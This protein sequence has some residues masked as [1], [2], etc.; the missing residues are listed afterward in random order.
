MNHG[1]PVGPEICL[2]HNSVIQAMQCPSVPA[3]E[4]TARF[5]R[6][7]SREVD[8]VIESKMDPRYPVVFGACLTQFTIVGLL[9]TVG[10]FFD[11]FEEEFGWSRTILSGSSSLAFLS[12]G[13]LAYFG[14]RLSDRYGPTVVLATTGLLY[15]MGFALISVV[16]E[17][18][19]LVALFGIFLGMGLATHDV[20]TLSTIARWF[21]PR[22]GLMTGVVKVGTAVGQ[23]VLPLLAA[24]LMAAV[25]WRYAALALGYGAAALLLIAAFSVAAPPKNRISAQSDARSAA[26]SDAQSTARATAQSTEHQ[27]PAFAAVRRGRTFRTLCLIQFLFF[28]SLM[29]VPLHIAVHGIDLGMTRT[30][31]A[32]LLTLIG[33]ASAAGRMAV[34][35]FSD[36]IGGR[37]AYILSLILLVAALLLLLTVRTHWALFATIALYGF[38]H[39]GLFTVVSPTV[40]EFFGTRAHGAIFGGVVFFGTIGAAVGPLMAGRVFDLTGSYDLAFGTL[41]TMSAG[42]LGLALTLPRRR[43]AQLARANTR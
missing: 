3:P 18:W 36:R 11:V 29:T 41:A 32:T 39:G 9:F 6:G 13:V 5:C 22:R 21:G 42:A 8:F 38:A 30:T 27:G 43:S 1:I 31:A 2:H 17:P 19:Q 40:A 34:G 14:G 35:T 23:M 25:G 10:L 16:G 28:P 37:N 4:A 24:V 33:G 20:V 7:P 15:G 12:M 26:Q